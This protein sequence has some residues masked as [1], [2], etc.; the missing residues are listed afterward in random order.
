MKLERKPAGFTL[1]EVM[2]VVAIIGLLASI[3][4]PNF[5]HSRELA[6]RKVCVGNLRQLEGAVQSWALEKRKYN[7]D[8]I[9]SAELFGS[10][11]YIKTQVI[12]PA[13][14]T[15]SYGLVGD[16]QHVGCSLAAAPNLHTL[17]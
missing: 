13:G 7:G 10:A 2:I 17:Y 11:S 12:C 6:H 1:V 8:S 16:P 4:V 9:V 14:G 3:A 5:I 15:Y